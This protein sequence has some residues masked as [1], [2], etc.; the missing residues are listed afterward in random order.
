M[1]GV[2][3][4]K[5][6]CIEVMK[7]MPD[8]CIDLVVTDPPYKLTSRGSSGTMSGYWAEDKAKKGVVFDS[9][10]TDIKDYIGGLYRILKDG[11]HCYIM[12]NQLNLPHFLE[13][14][15]KSEFKYIKCL[16]WDKCNKIYGRYYMNCFEYIIMLRKGRERQINLC[17]T[18]DIL[19]IPNKKTK[20]IDGKNIH[21]SQKPIS[22]MEILIKNS[23]NEGDVVLDC[24]VGSGTSG[25]AA[26][27]C[28]R[29]F[30]GIEIDDK[31]FEIAQERVKD[32]QNKLTLF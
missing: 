9:N 8:N 14:I 15:G 31:Y 20:D 2:K 6:D 13:V 29:N 16:I 12:C 32:A 18:P 21:D 4:Y 1:N 11:T 27:R 17:G 7:Q 19:S 28:G 26:M 5:G 24:F 22:L 23:S 30:I 3:L 25:L 10:D